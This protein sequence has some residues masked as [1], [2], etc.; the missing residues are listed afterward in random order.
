MR[1]PLILLFGNSASAAGFY[2]KI[3]E[4]LR[5]VGTGATSRVPTDLDFYR[6][7]LDELFGIFGEDRLLFGSDWPN[8]DNWAP[9]PQVFGIVHE[10]FTCR[11]GQ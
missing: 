3:S 9:Y 10:Y 4:V 11:E 1:L 5:R 7:K 8:S 6:P 2:V